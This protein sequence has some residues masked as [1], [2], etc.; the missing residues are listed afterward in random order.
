MG[1]GWRRGEFSKP[2]KIREDGK[3]NVA[4]IP[5]LHL[6]LGKEENGN[7]INITPES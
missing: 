1:W 2:G 7:N 3:E 4:V 5:T 6:S